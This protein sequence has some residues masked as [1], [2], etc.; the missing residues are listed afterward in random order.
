MQISVYIEILL[1]IRQVHAARTDKKTAQRFAHDSLIY[2]AYW[3]TK[4]V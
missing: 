1:K 3:T 4:H 2:C